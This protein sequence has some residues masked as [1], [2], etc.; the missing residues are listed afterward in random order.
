MIDHKFTSHF[1]NLEDVSLLNI[2]SLGLLCMHL[3][4]QQVIISENKPVKVNVFILLG[5]NDFVN[6]SWSI[7][8]ALFI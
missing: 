7:N 1:S 5:I 8:W 6:Q 4:V 3:C 2:H